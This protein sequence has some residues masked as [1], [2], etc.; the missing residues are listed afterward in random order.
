MTATI[1]ATR[2][3]ETNKQV[4]I[5]RITS[6]ATQK[7]TLII[8]HTDSPTWQQTL[9]WM[10]ATLWRML[11]LW[12]MIT[13]GMG[14]KGNRATGVIEGLEA[15]QVEITTVETGENWNSAADWSEDNMPQQNRV[16]PNPQP[17]TRPKQSYQAQRSSRGH[18]SFQEQRYKDRQ[19]RTSIR[20]SQL[21]ASATPFMPGAQQ[22]QEAGLCQ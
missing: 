16:E 15:P 4:F 10:K 18:A 9:V 2:T 19:S 13:W 21:N 12:C 20:D 22:H 14:N 11:K 3:Q 6:L 8:L 17:G 5:T 1:H 7:T